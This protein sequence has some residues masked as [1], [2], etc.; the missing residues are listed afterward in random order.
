M[1]KVVVSYFG[2]SHH[3]QESLF[4][5]QNFQ[6]F[7]Q[8][9]FPAFQYPLS[10]RAAAR[11]A[12]SSLFAS[13]YSKR[14]SHIGDKSGGDD[15]SNPDETNGP[16]TTDLPSDSKLSETRASKTSTDSS[17]SS[18]SASSVSSSGSQTS[19]SGCPLTSYI[20]SLTPGTDLKTLDT[21][22]GTVTGSVSS[23]AISNSADATTALSS[24]TSASGCPLTSY[25]FSLTP[26]TDM[27]TLDTGSGLGS[28]SPTSSSDVTTGS[29][30]PSSQIGT[31]SASKSNRSPSTSVAT[32]TTPTPDCMA[33]GAPW[34]SPTSWCDCAT[35]GTNSAFPTLPPSSGVTG[36]SA[37]CAYTSLDPSKTI[38]PVSVSA[39][40]TNIPG[41]NGVPGCAPVLQGD[42]QGCPNV[43]YCNCGG[44]YVDFLTATVSG[45]MSRNCDVKFPCISKELL[46]DINLITVHN[47]AYSQQLPH[48]HCSCNLGVAGSRIS[49]RGI[50]RKNP[51]RCTRSPIL[52]RPGQPSRCLVTR[53]SQRIRPQSRLLRSGHR[54]VLWSKMQRQLGLS[55]RHRPDSHFRYGR[56]S[57]VVLMQ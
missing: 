24:S 13:A 46:S 41:M 39:A 25:T 53:R 12:V 4:N 18:S 32:K 10:K 34:Y 40:P 16:K 9:P 35:S 5:S 23:V 48:Q 21:G 7:L 43:D 56:D 1:V 28:D 22:S 55:L 29:A 52:Q 57:S 26:G 37:N 44:T 45:T 19:N 27:K 38:K 31:T 54:R 15:S 50:C 3:F 47:P 36:S 42:G 30:P 8:S 11:P 6:D 17:I 51:D 33:D 14:S 20:F 2:T 49:V